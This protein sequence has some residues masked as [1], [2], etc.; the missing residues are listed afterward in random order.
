MLFNSYIFIFIFIPLTLLLYFGLNHFGKNILAK[1]SLI[2]MSL[3]FYGFFN[4]K[5]LPIIVI[6]I[7]FNYSLQKVFF[8]FPKENANKIR[9]T[10]LVMGIIFNIGILFYFK[11]FA[12]FMEN[13]NIVFRTDYMVERLVLPLGISFFTFQ[14]VSYIIDSY[15][16]EVSNYSIVDYALFVLFFPQLI[17]GPI[18][19]HNEIIPQ[20][21]KE[22]NQKFNF[23]NFYR[24]VVAFSI[25]LSK[26]VLL[27]DIFGNAVKWA[28]ANIDILDTTNALLSMLAYTLQIYFDF[29]GYCDMAIGLG[30]MMN[31]R[32]PINFNSPYKAKTIQDFW[33]RWHISL[34]RFFRTYVYFLLGGNQKGKVRTYLN[35][36]IVFLLSGLWHGANWTFILWGAL[37]G[38]GVI[39]SRLCKKI[40]NKIPY[41]VLWPITF[42]YINLLWVLFRADGIAESGQFFL[43]LLEFKFGPVNQNVIKVFELPE[44]MFAIEKISNRFSF[45]MEFVPLFLM[46]AFFTISMWMILFRKNTSE[47]IG[48]NTSFSPS[49]WQSGKTIILLVWS[50]ISFTGISTFLYFNF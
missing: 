40:E 48:I 23:E 4:I 33:K 6:S 1:L 17:A 14:Q 49:L 30:L 25:G 16:G 32:I 39:I 8:R 35:V 19:L 46:L 24:G 34:T 13:V 22:E 12:F 27:A 20:F 36:F 26:K 5:Y 21:Q 45:N 28:F 11:Y 41:I 7:I 42:L 2:G 29:S 44:F 3:W 31:I 18:V 38:V 10:I 50:L 15:R 43:K 9:K 47:I 37:H